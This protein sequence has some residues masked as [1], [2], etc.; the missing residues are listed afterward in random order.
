[1]VKLDSIR[2][3][4]RKYLEKLHEGTCTITEFSNV[5]DPATHRTKPVKNVI[6]EGVTCHLSYSTS[7]AAKN[8]ATVAAM[9]Q[10]T[11]LFISPDITVKPG[12]IVEVT[13]AGRITEFEASGAPVVYPTHQ[14]IGLTLTDKEA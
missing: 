13:Q 1:M 2:K 14:E 5:Y 11:T 3:L 8:T 7:L 10:N 6:C 9:D 4:A 12:S